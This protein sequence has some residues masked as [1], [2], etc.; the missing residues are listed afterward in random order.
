MTSIDEIMNSLTSEQ[1]IALLD[2]WFG[3][4]PAEF[5]DMSDDELLAAL[6]DDESEK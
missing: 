3:P 5:K 6:F 2:A 1:Y 4:A